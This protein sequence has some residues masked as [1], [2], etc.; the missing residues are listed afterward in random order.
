MIMRKRTLMVAGVIVSMS[1]SAAPAS[2]LD[3]SYCTVCHGA[4]GNGNPAIRAPKI[5][6][7][8]TWYVKRQLQLFRAGLRGV[9]AEDVTG[10]EMRPMAVHLRDDGALDQA[11]AHVASFVPKPPPITVS[12]DSTRGKQIY[13]SC[14]SCHGA[15]A[16][17]N[18]DLNA[19][20]LASST[21]WYLVTQLKSYMKGLRGAHEQDIYG[22][23]MRAIAATL[24]DEQ[25]A[26]DVIAYVNTLR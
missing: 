8:E 15:R 12:G 3:L 2:D 26:S 25:A 1:F 9:H 10:N 20:A 11:V 24:P 14:A 7:M 21:D 19:P 18:P 23:Q 6:G 16:E 4:N 22:T 17:G 13:E 5:A